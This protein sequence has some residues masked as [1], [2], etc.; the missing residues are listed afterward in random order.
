MVDVNE[1][2][3]HDKNPRIH[4]KSALEKL[5]RSIKEFGW[6][7]PV[8]VSADGIVLAGH[9]RLKAA[10]MAGITEVPVIYLPLSGAQA[11][12]YMIADNKL[13]EETTWELPLL[14]ELLQG[15]DGAAYDITK[16]GFSMAEFEKLVKAT[17]PDEDNFDLD[18][19]V[20]EAETP[21][22]K[23]GD[24]WV[25]GRHRVMCGDSTNQIEMDV[26]MDGKQADVVFTD[27][28]WNVDYGADEKHPSWKARQIMNDNMSTEEFRQFMVGAYTCMKAAVKPGAMVYVVM[29]AQEWGSMMQ[30]MAECGF[31]WSSTV[32]WCKDHPVLSR[33]DYH[34][35][36]EPLWYGWEGSAA[37]IHPLEDR[38]QNDVW[39]NARPV[40][41]ELHPTTKPIELVARALKNSS[42]LRD[43][44][45][46]QFGGSGST[47]IAA[48]QNDR[49]CFMMEL[50]PKY[51]DVIAK[52]YEAL[53]GQTGQ[54]IR[55]PE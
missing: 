23:R 19:A 27:P 55:A 12:A 29:S 48:E 25:L 43:L 18:K 15:L 33:K 44:V 3:M 24:I 20:K 46:D 1:L 49:S 9:A 45:L 31:H 32:I 34:T 54:L 37:R 35:R 6:T 53:T 22:T 41:S 11:D 36:Y 26:L 16:T 30:A 5:V 47:L 14:S 17:A 10:K 50:D 13:Q 8:L 52:R 28:P 4:P 40:A 21:I 42:N 38:K 7:N 2:K 39:E 51:C